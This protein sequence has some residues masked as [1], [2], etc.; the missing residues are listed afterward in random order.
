MSDQYLPTIKQIIE[1]GD[2]L[3]GKAMSDEECKVW[4]E[5]TVEQ[6]KASSQSGERSR[7]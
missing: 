3:H 4:F 5:W 1:K 2:S 6:N 7:K